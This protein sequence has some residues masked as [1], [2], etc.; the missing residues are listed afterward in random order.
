MYSFHATCNLHTRRNDAHCQGCWVGLTAGLDRHRKSRPPTWIQLPDHPA[1][2][3]LPYQLHHS[4]CLGG[5]LFHLHLYHIKTAFQ[6]TIINDKTVMS[7]KISQNLIWPS[8]NTK[9]FLFY[10]KAPQIC[11]FLLVL[12][13]GIDKTNWKASL[14]Y[15]AF[16][17][18]T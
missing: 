11:P 3:R 15:N 4:S 17:L 13:R 10:L 7:V 18:Y 16:I 6:I 5:S 8:R 1:H 12:H 2:S 14:P 9:G